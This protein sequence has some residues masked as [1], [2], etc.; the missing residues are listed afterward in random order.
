MIDTLPSN[1]ILS[2]EDFHVPADISTKFNIQSFSDKSIETALSSHLETQEDAFFLV[3]LGTV[4]KQLNKWRTHLPRVTPFY[5]VKCNP[6]PGILSTLASLGVNFDCASKNEI[7][8]V[9]S[10]GVDPSRIIFANPT[11][12][13]SHIQYA[14]NCGVSLMTFDNSFE[15]QKISETYPEASLILRIITD[16]SQ[17]L[18]KFSSKFGAPLPQVNNLLAL[19][20]QLNLNI[21]GVSFHVGSSCKDPKAFLAAVTTAHSIFESAKDFGFNLQILDLGG[22]W[23]GDDNEGIS[24]AEIAECI[25]DKMDQLFPQIQIIAEP[26]RYFVAQSHTL[27]VNVFAKRLVPSDTSPSFLYYLNDGVYQSFNCLFFDHVHLVPEVLKKKGEN[28]YKCT[29]FGPTCDSI[30]CIARDIQ[31]PELDIGDWL[32]FRNMGAYTTAA[33]CEFNGFSASKPIYYINS[34]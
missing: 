13:K 11:K 10:F 33:A 18:C 30:D 5:A 34:Q 25:R 15:L 19:A 32:F 1:D 20:Q 6:N 9:L 24:F 8:K 12:M 23:P 3:D 29:L 31:L 14:K 7:Q 28:T 26:G 27:A 4:V 22:G 2:F 16:D 17:S 21:V